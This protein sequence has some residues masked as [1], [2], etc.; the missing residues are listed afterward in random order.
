MNEFTFIESIKQEFYR[1][2]TLEKGIGDDAAVFYQESKRIVTA[3]DTFVENI[4]FS[5]QT[6]T[7]SQIGYRALA[8]NLSDLAAM[9]AIPAFL[10]TSVVIPKTW[11]MKEIQQIFTGL[12]DLASQY[13][14]DLI[15]GDTVSGE[16]LVLTI[17]VIG[18]VEKDKIR[19]RHLAKPEDIVFVTGTVGDSRAGLYMLMHPDEY[20]H[21]SHFIQSHQMPS[22]RVEFA[23]ALS[24]VK[25]LCLND[26]SDGLGNEAIEIAEA[27][28]VELILEEKFIPTSQGF[29]QFDV[30]QQE[31]WK[32]FGGED[33]E[34]LGTVSPADWGKVQTIADQ[35]D[36]QVTKI[37]VV[38]QG[39]RGKVYLMK[40]NHYVKPLKK[41][42]YRHLK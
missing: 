28:Q 22:P 8:V 42:G 41:D 38:R 25:R 39:C 7:P 2:P 9:G 16:E 24:D 3:V 34:L 36:L 14:M 6:M 10:L 29:S 20:T 23:R 27:S 30:E 37:G 35:L 12:K 11:E 33:F 5:R 26:V 21:A 13:K 17:T 4:H 40:G 1:Q 18:Y 31:Q 19:Y 32:L 15:G